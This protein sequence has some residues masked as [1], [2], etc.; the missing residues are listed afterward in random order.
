MKQQNAK[1]L[2]CRKTSVWKMY[3]TFNLLGRNI[4][5]DSLLFP[6]SSLSDK[7]SPCSCISSFFD[8]WDI[9]TCIPLIMVLN[10]ECIY[11]CIKS[12][13]LY[14]NKNKRCSYSF[15]LKFT[16]SCVVRLISD[17]CYVKWSQPIQRLVNQWTMNT[18]DMKGIIARRSFKP[19]KG[20]VRVNDF[21]RVFKRRLNIVK[22]KVP[23]I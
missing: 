12:S 10:E 16:G 9:T 1:S 23:C 6:R 3:T 22:V 15:D 11:F 18:D 2:T 4:I 5:T 19:V 17:Q 21:T 8:W 14:V 20:I 13:F 7:H